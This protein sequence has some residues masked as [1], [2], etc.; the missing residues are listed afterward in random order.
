MIWSFAIPGGLLAALM[1]VDEI[2]FHRRRELPRWERI[3]HPLDTLSVVI[4][5]TLTLILTPNSQALLIYGLLS[6]GSCLL[7]SK[8]EKVHARRCEA[9]E[10]WLHAMLFM[11]HPLALLGGAVLWLAPRAGELGIVLSARD[12]ASA[13][14]VLVAQVCLALL[15]GLYQLIYWNVRWRR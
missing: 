15:F 13:R 5:Y 11:L 2:C 3:G 14:F 10:H 7:V 12:L 8:D 6:V 9:G 1:F 4:C